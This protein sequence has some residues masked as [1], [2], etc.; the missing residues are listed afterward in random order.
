MASVKVDIPEATKPFEAEL[1][2]SYEKPSKKRFCMLK[3]LLYI[4]AILSCGVTLCLLY[5]KIC[6][7]EQKVSLENQALIDSVMVDDTTSKIEEIPD[8]EV[9]KSILGSDFPCLSREVRN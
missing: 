6:T 9:N 1:D 8:H 7:V 2:K 3:D 4:I 5:V